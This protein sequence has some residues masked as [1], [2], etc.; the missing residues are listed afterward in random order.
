MVELFAT[1]MDNILAVKRTRNHM[2]ENVLDVLTYMFESYFEE[3]DAV[4][5]RETLLEELVEVGFE[6]SEVEKAFNWLADLPTSHEDLELT[7]PNGHAIRI[8]CPWESKKLDLNC[9][10]YLLE[11]EQMGILTPAIR[12]LVIDR[13]MALET[14]EI[15]IDQ[16]R[17]V[18][19]IVLYNLSGSELPYNWLEDVIMDLSSSHIH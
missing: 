4:F 11:L 15:S 14:D 3:V 16:L 5:N 9:Q 7:S 8:Y 17:W 1:P 10:G 6:H 18:C 12:E 13:V 19:L 2:K